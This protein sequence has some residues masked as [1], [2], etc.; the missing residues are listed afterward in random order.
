MHAELGPHAVDSL[1]ICVRLDHHRRSQPML[2]LLLTAASSRALVLVDRAPCHAPV[3][4]RTP[5]S[6]IVAAAKPE[7]T[8]CQGSVCSK[9]GTKEIQA[10]A[11]K[12]GL[13]VKATKTC[14]KG[15]GKGVN[16]S[17]KGLG[18]KSL[19]GCTDTAKAQAATDQIAKKLG[20]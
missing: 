18:K 11:R 20:L 2:A 1:C 5:R 19:K 3:G 16:V 17:A 4:Q 7:L 9:W 8:V 13:A 15:C 10:A 14:L 12:S 6:L